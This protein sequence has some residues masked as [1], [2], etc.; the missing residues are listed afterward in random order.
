MVAGAGLVATAV[1]MAAPP[2]AFGAAITV[3]LGGFALST[4][5][6]ALACGTKI[7]PEDALVLAKLIDK[8]KHIA[9]QLEQMEDNGK[10]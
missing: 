6:A 4:T 8:T 2:L 9:T 5:S 1:V 7:K 10:S 3:F